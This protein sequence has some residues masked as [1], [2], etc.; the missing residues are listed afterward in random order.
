M[1]SRKPVIIGL[2]EVLWDMLPGGK[3]LGGAP[4]NFAYHCRQIGAE[5]YVVSAVGKDDLGC[6]ILEV[7]GRL[8]LPTEYVQ[9]EENHPTSTVTVKLN[10]AGHPDYTIHQNVAWDYMPVEERSLELMAAA[11]AICFGTLAQRSPLTRKS[12]NSY[13]EAAGPDC[14]KVFDIN[15][16]Q[17]YFTQETLENSLGIANILKLNDDE[18][19]V[20]A[21]MFSLGDDQP[22]QAEKLMRMFD[23]QLV[24]LTK[25]EAGSSLFTAKESSDYLSDPVKTEDTVG[26]GDSFTAAMI[27]GL[28]KGLNLK[29]LHR[30]ASDLA[31]F[32]CTQKGATPGL[33]EGLINELQ[34]L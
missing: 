31:A 13:L 10:H 15:L 11:D 25:G 32:V 21:E 26:A 1:T 9:I 24:A 19:E 2:G 28:L 23:L 30:L 3:I 8:Q 34:S 27:M 6:E 7:M 14:L 4:A 29:D 33:P 17:T 5:S 22:V 12:V 16:R 18:L 20:L